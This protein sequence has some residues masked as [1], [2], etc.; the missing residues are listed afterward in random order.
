MGTSDGK[1]SY[2]HL[3]KKGVD[4]SEYNTMGVSAK[5]LLFTEITDKYQLTELAETG[6]FDHENWLLFGG[7]SN[8]LFK[9]DL[10]RP[11]LHMAITGIEV[12]N[13]SDKNMLLIQL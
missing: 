12:L 9:T 10:N 13:E 6:F 3:F 5:A 4:L 1:H 8:I 2:N 11:V 7:G